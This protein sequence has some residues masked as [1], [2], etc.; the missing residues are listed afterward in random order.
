MQKKRTQ[1]IKGRAKKCLQTPQPC[2]MQHRNKK[3]SNSCEFPHHPELKITESGSRKIIL[4]FSLVFLPFFLDD[5]SL[6]NR[7]KKGYGF[8]QWEESGAI[9]GGETVDQNLY[10]KKKPFQLK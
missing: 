2:S 1:V 9:R 10:G 8:G 7:I 3:F 4:C 5:G 6:M